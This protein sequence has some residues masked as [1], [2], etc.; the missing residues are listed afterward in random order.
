MVLN[1]CPSLYMVVENCP[2]QYKVVHGFYKVIHGCTRL[3]YMYTVHSLIRLED[4]FVDRWN[5]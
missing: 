2:W 3:L 1:A 5:L 4:L